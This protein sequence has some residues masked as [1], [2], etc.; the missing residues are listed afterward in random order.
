MKIIACLK[1][2]RKSINRWHR[3]G[4]HQGYLTFVDQYIA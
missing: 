2:I 3:R 4:G 1:R